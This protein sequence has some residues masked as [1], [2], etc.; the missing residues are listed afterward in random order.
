MVFRC[1]ELIYTLMFVIVSMWFLGSHMTERVKR[2]LSLDCCNFIA[3][4]CN[5]KCMPQMF[6]ITR[7]NPVVQSMQRGL[8]LS[9]LVLELSRFVQI[10]LEG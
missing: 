2:I 8:E 5:L 9:R 3:G 6:V 4:C 1:N 10:A 7:V